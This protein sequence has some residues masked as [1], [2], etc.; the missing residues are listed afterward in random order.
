MAIGGSMLRKSPIPC[1]EA[2]QLV[3]AG[4][5]SLCSSSRRSINVR[6]APLRLLDPVGGPR[7]HHP[8]HEEKYWS[9]GPDDKLHDLE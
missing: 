2:E 6:L 1:E 7:D 9:E 8:E 3:Q 5:I 4:A